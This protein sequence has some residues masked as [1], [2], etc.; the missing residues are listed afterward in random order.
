MAT[1]EKNVATLP[2]LLPTSAEARANLLE[3]ESSLK[4]LCEEYYMRFVGSQRGTIGVR[5]AGRVVADIHR[6]LCL[7]VPCEEALYG[8]MM[9][10]ACEAFT[11]DRGGFVAFIETVLHQCIAGVPLGV[12]GAATSP[13]KHLDADMEAS[14]PPTPVGTIT[15][16]VNKLDGTSADIT[17]NNVE[18]IDT[19]QESVQEELG[20]PKALQRLICGNSILDSKRPLF[21]QG[22]SDGEE[23]TVIHCKPQA[24][25]L[26]IRR[27]NIGD[28]SVPCKTPPGPCTKPS[29]AAVPKFDLVAPKTECA[30]SKDELS[31]QIEAVHLPA[32]SEKKLAAKPPLRSQSGKH[33]RPPSTFRIRR[34]N[35]GRA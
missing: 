14:R 11:L 16:C 15:V 29:A 13:S 17:V 7:P 3:D 33:C 4:Q 32:Q 12:E 28:T 30:F 5:V 26:R 21:E 10:H 24:T 18:N 6:E 8:A 9:Q 22:V 34:C 35:L 19:L 20:V 27:C 1:I 23:I 2:S 25:L 31:K